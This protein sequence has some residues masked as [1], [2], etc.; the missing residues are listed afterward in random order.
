M[1]REKFN[2]SIQAE[3]APMKERE[4]RDALDRG[5][6]RMQAIQEMNGGGSGSSVDKHRRELEKHANEDSRKGKI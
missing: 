3:Q 4:V 5:A 6:K 2:T 1:T